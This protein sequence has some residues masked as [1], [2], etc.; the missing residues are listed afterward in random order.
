V[1]FAVRRIDGE[2][3]GIAMSEELFDSQPQ[4]TLKQERMQL[5]VKIF[6]FRAILEERGNKQ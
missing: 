5:P 1:H 2:Q 3:T 6:R 4:G